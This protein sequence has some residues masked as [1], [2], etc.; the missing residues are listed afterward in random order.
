MNFN[1]VIIAFHFF[2]HYKFHYL[3]FKIA[4]YVNTYRKLL[5]RYVCFSTK[6]IKMPALNQQCLMPS[7]VAFYS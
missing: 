3:N 1:H 5:A 4:A 2:S 7:N 6:R